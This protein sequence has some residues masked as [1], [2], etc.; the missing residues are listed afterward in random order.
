MFDLK[1]FDDLYN[2]IEV[3]FVLHFDQKSIENIV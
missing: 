1:G 3:L 2:D